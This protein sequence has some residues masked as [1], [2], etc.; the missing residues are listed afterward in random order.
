MKFILYVIAGNTTKFNISIVCV[1]LK[2]FLYRKE[3]NLLMLKFDTCSCLSH[4]K[5][6]LIYSPKYL[7]ASELS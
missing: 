3:I 2:H 5:S 4:V 1:A 6:K 7:Y